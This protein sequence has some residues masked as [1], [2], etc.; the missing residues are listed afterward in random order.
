[1]NQVIS[2]GIRVVKYSVWII[3]LA[4]FLACPSEL[5]CLKLSPLLLW[6]NMGDCS[7]RVSQ[8]VALILLQF[9]SPMFASKAAMPFTH[10]TCSYCGIKERL[11]TVID[12]LAVV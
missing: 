8:S 10:W 2:T 6:L 7:I 4:L 9:P 5:Q 11:F 1:M 12:K 3:N